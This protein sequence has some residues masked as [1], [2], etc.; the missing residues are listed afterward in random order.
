MQFIRV[1][2]RSVGPPS[3]KLWPNLIFAQFPH[4]NN[5]GGVGGSPV[6]REGDIFGKKAFCDISFYVQEYER[7]V[8]FRLGRLLTS[9]ARGWV[10]RT[11]HYYYFKIHPHCD[12]RFLINIFHKRAGRATMFSP[13]R[14]KCCWHLNV[15]VRRL[16]HSLGK[17]SKNVLADFFR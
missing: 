11:P 14:Y 2:F 17:L 6:L 1:D 8:I 10:D 7:A 13:K 3:Q 12:L 15:R 4:W 5:N 9:G 16:Q